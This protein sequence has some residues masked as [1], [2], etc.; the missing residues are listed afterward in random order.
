VGTNPPVSATCSTEWLA[1]GYELEAEDLVVSGGVKFAVKL[2]TRKAAYIEEETHGYEV[3]LVGAHAEHSPPVDTSQSGN[4]RRLEIQRDREPAPRVSMSRTPWTSASLAS[5][6][7]GDSRCRSST[8]R[9]VER[10]LPGLLSKP[11]EEIGE[12]HSDGDL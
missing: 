6:H 4:R 10:L 5:A 12:C 7:A 9:G 3:D 2:P 1:F 8:I 11:S